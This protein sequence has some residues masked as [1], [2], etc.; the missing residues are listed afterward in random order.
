MLATFILALQQINIEEKIE[1]AP[2]KSYE[3]GIVIGTYLPFVALVLIAYFIFYRAK[4]R[5]DLND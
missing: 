4:N 2:D 1:N 5:K 3:I